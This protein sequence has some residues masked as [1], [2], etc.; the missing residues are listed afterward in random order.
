MSCGNPH[1]TPCSEVL[2]DVYAY[3]D[4]EIDDAT[5][6]RVKQHLDECNPCLRQYGLEQ[7]VKSLVARSCGCEH[8]PERLRVSVMARIQQVRVTYRNDG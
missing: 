2:A 3:L 6:A 1:D 5:R 8:A 7:V 4:G